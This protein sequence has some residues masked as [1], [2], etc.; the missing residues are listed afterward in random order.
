MCGHSPYDSNISAMNSIH[1]IRLSSEINQLKSIVKQQN[2]LLRDLTSEVTE[3]RQIIGVKRKNDSSNDITMTYVEHWDTLDQKLSSNM[4]MIVFNWHSSEV[5]ASTNNVPQDMKRKVRS[6]KSK[7]HA[8]VKKLELLGITNGLTLASK[9]NDIHKLVPWK[10]A[11]KEFSSKCFDLAKE[12][13]DKVK[14]VKIRGNDFKLTHMAKI[15]GN[16]KDDDEH[17]HSMAGK[18]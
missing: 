3:L 9:P 16:M 1:N 12:D 17:I 5:E 8:V 6:K 18:D 10:V 11:A 4:Q 13:N 2:T 7:I 14:Y 15:L